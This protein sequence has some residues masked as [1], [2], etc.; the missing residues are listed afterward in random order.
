M[1]SHVSRERP[2]S[3]AGSCSSKYVRT[4][5][6]H[7]RGAVEIDRSVDRVRGAAALIAT[8]AA[9]SLGSGEHTGVTAQWAEFRQCGQFAPARQERKASPEWTT[10]RSSE[11]H[12]HMARKRREMRDNDRRVR[13]AA[14]HRARAGQVHV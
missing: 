14:G 7:R 4:N 10:G 8:N 9:T 1:G 6:L 5:V 2:K 13:R 3:M 11:R 12:T